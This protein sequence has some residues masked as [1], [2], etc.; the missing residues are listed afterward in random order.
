M[1]KTIKCVQQPSYKT[2][3]NKKK[4]YIQELNELITQNSSPLCV[5]HSRSK[6]DSYSWSSL[7]VI[8]QHFTSFHMLCSTN[9]TLQV[10]RRTKCMLL[11]AHGEF[12]HVS[13]ADDRPHCG[14]VTPL[15]KLADDGLLQLHSA[16][17]NM[18]D[19]MTKALMKWTVDHQ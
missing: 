12:C 17:N 19:L 15:I 10:P 13:A 3:I 4:N 6:S 16:D 5:H 1:H 18:A 11:R 8:I 7:E 14:F 2:I 9:C